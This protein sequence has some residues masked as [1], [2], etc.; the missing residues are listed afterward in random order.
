MNKLFKNPLV[1]L[2]LVLVVGGLIFTSLNK[3]STPTAGEFAWS[4]SQVEDPE[5][6]AN[7][8]VDVFL[9]GDK[10]T[11]TQAL[12][13]DGSLDTDLLTLESAESGGF[14]ENSLTVKMDTKEM[15]FALAKNPTTQN[16]I[17]PSKPVI[18]L[19]FKP[20]KGFE[21]AT[22]RVLPQSQIYIKNVGG[23]NPTEAAAVLQK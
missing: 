13:I 22:F 1:L 17:D 21:E 18:K 5:N 6:P 2:V 15:V 16:S 19:Y 23:A 8:E 10:V 9:S 4:I 14:F 7:Y 11:E 3:K 12:E 20:K